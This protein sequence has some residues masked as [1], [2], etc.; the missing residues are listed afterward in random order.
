MNKPR[1][2]Q[3]PLA[4]SF[5]EIRSELLAYLSRYVGDSSTAEDILHETFIKALTLDQQKA[6]KNMAAW[7]FRVAK[8]TAI[9]HYRK[10]DN[11]RDDKS[12]TEDFPSS[13][14]LL[15]E[16]E[17]KA[18]EELAN[19]LRKF[20]EHNIPVKYADTLIATQFSGQTLQQIADENQVTLSAIKSRAS[21][22]R[23]LLK[24]KLLQCCEIEL[25][26][27]QKVL[28]YKQKEPNNKC[29]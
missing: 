13:P 14:L 9:D 11:L 15:D 28:S 3:D 21:R 29:C 6:P 5:R 27:E 16:E 2:K 18:S 23:K 10:R 19:C 7:L 26:Q 4:N 20:T 22:G 8:N 1:S 12:I 25:S 24:E 17:N